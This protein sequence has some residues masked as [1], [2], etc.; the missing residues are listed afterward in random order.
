MRAGRARHRKKGQLSWHITI[1]ARVFLPPL[2]Q[3]SFDRVASG[4]RSVFALY[5]RTDNSRALDKTL[6]AEQTPQLRDCVRNVVAFNK[7]LFDYGDNYK[8][9]QF[10]TTNSN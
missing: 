8:F 1:V 9:R 10:V 6:F 4:A 3:F 5:F 7:Y 2:D